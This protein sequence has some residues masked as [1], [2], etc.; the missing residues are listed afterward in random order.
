VLIE[1]GVARRLKV[2]PGAKAAAGMARRKALESFIVK[3]HFLLDKLGVMILPARTSVKIA[4]FKNLAD[5]VRQTLVCVAYLR[6]PG[7]ATEQNKT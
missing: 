4:R 6:A 2:A 5:D 7:K 3:I 1:R